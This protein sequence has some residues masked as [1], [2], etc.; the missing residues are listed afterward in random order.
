M[1]TRE[2]VIPSLGLQYATEVINLESAIDLHV[3]VPTKI[4]LNIIRVN[5]AYQ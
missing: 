5:S 1:G 3:H 2:S 4:D